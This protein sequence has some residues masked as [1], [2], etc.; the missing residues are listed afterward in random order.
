[1]S[2][3]QWGTITFEVPDFL[4]DT[5]DSLNSVAEILITA[6]DVALIA[7]KLAKTF[8]VGYL[9]P[10]AS[11]VQ[12]FV[13]ELEGLLR[14]FQQL[15]MYITGDWKLLTWPYE[16][17]QGGFPEYERRMIGRLTDRTDPTRPDLPPTLQALAIF[18]YLSVDIS[19]IQ[20]LTNFILQ[21]VQFFNQSY[22]PPGGLPVPIITEIK[23]GAEAADILQPVTI[24][25]FFKRNPGGSPPNVAEVR[26]RVRPPV[27]K[28]PMNPFPPLPPGGFLVT[29]ST[30]KEGIKVVY[31]RP[32]A[33][34]GKV[35]GVSGTTSQPREY[36]VVRDSLGRPLVLHGGVSMLGSLPPEAEYNS[37]VEKGAVLD[38]KN[39][40][41][42]TI[43]NGAVIPLEEMSEYTNQPM[44]QQTFFVPL[45]YTA[46]QWATQEY[47]ITLRAKDMPLTGRVT[48]GSDGKISI[49]DPQKTSNFYVRVASCT[50][51]V[52]NKKQPYKYDL[53]KMLPLLKSP[54]L[55]PVAAMT[56]GAVSDASG[57]S[58][59][60]AITFPGTFTA[61]YLEAVQTALAVLYLCRPDLVPL[62]LL[63]QTL[64][65]EQRKA[66]ASKTLVLN[67]VAL[68]RCGLE[69]LQHLTGYLYRNYSQKVEERKNAP[70][71]FRKDL[72]DQI[73]R[74]AH[75]LYAKTGPMPEAE[76]AIVK[77]TELLRTVSWGD[78]FQAVHP[79]MHS[80]LPP[81]L[82]V[83]NI[84]L[85]L[86]NSNRQT[87]LATNPFSMG[88]SEVPSQML[89]YVDGLIRDRDPQMMEVEVG[90][91]DTSFT[92]KL[93]VPAKEAEQFL[94]GLSPSL[95]PIYEKYR[96]RD[97]S[98]VVPGSA[99]G[100]I[101]QLSTAV[102]KEGSA[103][104]SPVFFVNRQLLD[105]LSAP[106]DKVDPTRTGVFYV[107]GLLAK[108]NGGEILRQA[109][110]ALS[111]AGAAMQ[112]APQDGEWIPV[113]FFDQF[114]SLLEFFQQLVDWVKSIQV[115]IQ[116]I[117]DTI[118]KYIEFIEARIIEIQQLIQRINSLLQSL[119][120]YAF[121]IPKC[122]ALFLVSNG[123]DGL[124][125]D[126][127][128]AENKPSDS[129]LAYGA[130]I[131]VV[132]P[133][134]PAFVMDILRV[135]FKS[136]DGKPKEGE[137][138]GSDTLGFPD[139]FGIE[140]LP[141]PP[142]VPPDPPPDVL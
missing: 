25:E 141:A 11:L 139:A 38:N 51:P 49:E 13:D 104:G 137:M 133:F 35:T 118:L 111:V 44:F 23:Y 127:V 105:E 66:I 97:G 99:T 5:R 89:F 16:N 55:V 8:L 140:D 68:Q 81:T 2:D 114:P 39:R 40:V 37:A 123:T 47:R 82:K 91:T 95:L 77:Q 34:A 64:T 130:G 45:A 98:I 26:W 131:T 124:L 70:I 63:D 62:D 52:G 106:G 109:A 18:F 134:G 79:E 3:G 30:I 58:E 69:N 110:L 19:D 90:R 53:Q 80:Q 135:V 65:D 29:V 48:V 31:D 76:E 14:D 59:A 101:T 88:L 74:V 86:E 121:K 72:R 128:S 78:I 117:L 138:M 46:T 54:G 61:K 119:L 94:S 56:E 4:E 96:K 129:P 85:S 136:E 92:P 7:L 112:R 33:N 75:D 67:H 132:I 9:D 107:R 15:G 103:D 102:R 17:L 21:L 57:F 20:R 50:T 113:R 93:S 73:R 142:P 27:Q 100:L 115:S 6:L 43:S 125:A 24:P 32:Q 10:V 41:F 12:A 108:A 83:V 71:E 36:G 1:M 60:R 122:S 126:F 120:G 84:L 87:G 28:H 116:S 22:N 42:G